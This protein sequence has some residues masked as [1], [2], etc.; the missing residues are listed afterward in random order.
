MP[1]TLPNGVELDYA[2][3]GEGPR[4]V[5]IG[6]SGM[7]A[8]ALRCFQL[9]ALIDAGYQVVTFASR[10]LSPSQAPPP[11]YSIADMAADTAAL[12]Q[13][14]G[15]EPVRVVGLSLGGFIAEELARRR[16]EL[17][18]SVVLVAS[19]GRATA[20]VRTRFRAERELFASCAVP[21]SYDVARSRGDVLRPERFRT[22]T[23]PWN[24]GPR[25]SL[26]SAR[27]E[28]ALRAL[29]EARGGVAD[30]VCRGSDREENGG[31][32]VQSLDPSGWVGRSQVQILFPR[33]RRS[34][35]TCPCKAAV[36][37]VG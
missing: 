36:R 34:P 1:R 26:P 25:C 7:P 11:P 9:P 18:R 29:Q 24:G 16:P 28:Q 4:M 15:G 2:V 19:A 20:Y 21:H 32:Q 27:P 23:P 5:L 6:G 22:T 35:E 3:E 30:R 14:L 8:V 10:G 12:I 33:S 17:V 31:G 13:H 37:R